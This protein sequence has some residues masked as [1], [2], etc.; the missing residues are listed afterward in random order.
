MPPLYSLLKVSSIFQ[1]E[2]IF[3]QV[4][5]DS[6]CVDSLLF[7]FHKDSS[8]A[9]INDPAQAG[10]QAAI[11]PNRVFAL[12]KGQYNSFY[13]ATW[14]G[15]SA[16][17]LNH[18]VRFD[19]TTSTSIDSHQVRRLDLR[20]GDQV[21]VDKQGMRSKAWIVHSFGG[22]PNVTDQSQCMITS[23]W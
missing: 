5:W 21:K 19:D 3:L 20:V 7:S 9:V 2:T 17:G 22:I 8:S 15:S 6:S 11:A 14:L 1:S 12:F 16:D 10:Q 13:P 18:R 23:P 4:L